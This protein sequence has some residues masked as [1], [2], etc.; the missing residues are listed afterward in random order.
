MTE[1]KIMKE[2]EL[3]DRVWW[4]D[5][6]KRIERHRERKGKS[7]CPVMATRLG[8]YKVRFQNKSLFKFH[9]KLNEHRISLS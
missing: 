9:L 4:G 7:G 2:G 6:D 8:N 1:S 3:M 5:L